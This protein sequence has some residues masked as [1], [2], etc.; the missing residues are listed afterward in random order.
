MQL[1]QL[2]SKISAGP[3]ST[4]LLVFVGLILYGL[5]LGPNK[6]KTL[7]LSVY[8][9]IVIATELGAAAANLLISHHLG[10]RLSP[11]TVRLGLFALPLLI[12]E[13]GRKQH[14]KRG[15]SGMIVTLVL[16][17]LTAALIVS[18]GLQLL[19]PDSVNRIIGQS[20][21]GMWVY[22]LR[23]WWI[24]AVPLVVVGESLVRPKE[25]HY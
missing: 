14:G 12:L 19:G 22:R 5:V 24:V 8:V 15:H 23:L 1:H 4:M 3:D 25:P 9:G 18:A 17:V 11:G 16:C 10:G 20:T 6:V 13:F 21:L 7:A 2:A